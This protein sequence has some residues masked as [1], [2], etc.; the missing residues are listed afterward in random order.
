MVLKFDVHSEIGA[1]VWS[2]IGY[3]KIVTVSVRNLEIYIQTRILNRLPV[4]FY[5]VVNNKT[6]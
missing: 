4:L 2:D 3:K 6:K 1:Q 5:M